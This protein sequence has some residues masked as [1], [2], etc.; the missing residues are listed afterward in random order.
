MFLMSSMLEKIALIAEGSIR[1]R[2]RRGATNNYIDMDID[3]Y[4]D[5]DEESK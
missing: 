4:S 3:I 5:R 2:E 1:L